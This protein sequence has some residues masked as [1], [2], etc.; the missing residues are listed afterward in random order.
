[1]KD[2]PPPGVEIQPA[3]VYETMTGQ[4]ELWVDEAGYPRR[5]VL[6]LQFPRLSREY[7]VQAHIAVDFSTFGA[8]TEQT[9]VVPDAEGG[10]RVE[11]QPLSPPAARS[12]GLT[13]PS[14]EGWL[15]LCIWAAAI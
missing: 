12:G 6:D 2:A 8:V 3:A 10:W 14:R 9:T 1:M 7:Q 4:G 5:Q 13:L 11:T 15:S